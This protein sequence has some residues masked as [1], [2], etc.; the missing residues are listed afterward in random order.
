MTAYPWVS[1]WFARQNFGIVVIIHSSLNDLYLYINMQTCKFMILQSTGYKYIIH[2]QNYT[3]HT[4][5]TY[6]R[7]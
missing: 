1:L 7:K 6:I 5:K 2:V 4:I 3:T